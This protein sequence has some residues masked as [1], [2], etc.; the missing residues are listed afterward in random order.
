MRSD[1]HRVYRPPDDRI[2]L[3]EYPSES[4]ANEAE[5]FLILYY[6]RKDLGTGCLRNRT[7]GGEGARGRKGVR[8]TQAFKDA[9][10]ERNR[11]RVWSKEDCAVLIAFA[12]TRKRDSR[13]HFVN[14]G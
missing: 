5:I 3:Q 2:L 14:A 1:G 12:A 11:N 4:A 6:G 9:V 10:A 7:D 8:H 13:G